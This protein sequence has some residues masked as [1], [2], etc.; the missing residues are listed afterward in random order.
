MHQ[1]E[2]SKITLDLTQ[3]REKNVLMDPKLALSHGAN[4]MHKSYH[5]IVDLKREIKELHGKLLENEAV[6]K[7][8]EVDLDSTCR[9][10]EKMKNEHKQFV[11][12]SDKKVQLLLHDSDQK[13][14]AAR[15]EYQE[16]EKVLEDTNDKLR[17]AEERNT[18]YEE[19]HGLTDTLRY[20]RKLEA[21]IQMHNQDKK[22]LQIE[23]SKKDEQCQ[24]LQ[25][26]CDIFKEKAGLPPEY[27][28]DNPELKSI[29]RQQRNSLKSENRE[30][31]CQIKMLEQCRLDLMK[32][33]RMYATQISEKGIRVL[34]LTED[35]VIQATEFISNL[36]DGKIKLPLNDVSIDLTVSFSSFSNKDTPDTSRKVFN[37]KYSTFAQL[38]ICYKCSDKIK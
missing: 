25:I 23:L 37:Q 13:G 20:Q 26:C 30:L 11:E 19:S 3:E 21:D 33:M 18:R 9:M 28:L 34:G 24:I 22:Q 31:L 36:R 16:L 35:Q 38:Q 4:E 14:K 29:I 15:L 27:E 7:Q 8:I 1:K 10:L 32:K 5:Q 12:M 2:I 17:L 6:K